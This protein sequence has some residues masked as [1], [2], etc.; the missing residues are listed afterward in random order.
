MGANALAHWKHP[1][2]GA[3]DHFGPLTPRVF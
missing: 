2:T 1:G 3:V